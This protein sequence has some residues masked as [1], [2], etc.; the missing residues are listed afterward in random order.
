MSQVVPDGIVCFFTSYSYLEGII[1]VWN[2][3]GIIK[4]ILRYML[5]FIETTDQ[6]ESSVALENYR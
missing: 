5:L 3:M 2:D 4:Q 1:S 6:I